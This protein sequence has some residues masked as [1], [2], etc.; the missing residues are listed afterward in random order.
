M[1]DILLECLKRIQ[2]EIRNLEQQLVAIEPKDYLKGN[3]LITAAKRVE[4]SDEFAKLVKFCA[5]VSGKSPSHLEGPLSLFLKQSGAYL[6]YNITDAS[7]VDILLENLH[8]LL[9]PTSDVSVTYLLSLPWVDASDVPVPVKFGNYWV[10]KLSEEDLENILNNQV[11]EVFFPYSSIDRETLFLL[12]QECWLEVN[13]FEPPPDIDSFTIDFSSLFGRITYTNLPSIVERALGCLILLDWHLHNDSYNDT[14]WTGLP[15]GTLIKISD[16]WFEPPVKPIINIMAY[17]FVEKDLPALLL[18]QYTCSDLTY[19]NE[20][21]N[22]LQ[23]LEGSE[24]TSFVVRHVLRYLLRAAIREVDGPGKAVQFIDHVLCLEALLG[25]DKPGMSGRLA[26]RIGTLI[27]RRKCKVVERYFKRIYKYRSKL[28]HG[29]E[30]DSIEP[31]LSWLARR[32][33]WKAIIRAVD[34]LYHYKVKGYNLSQE[35]FIHILDALKTE[36]EPVE[37]GNILQLWPDNDN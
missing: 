16:N 20:L 19:L 21:E 32:L 7:L 27:D 8:E 31:E 29:T 28:L 30:I 5:G 1:R 33:A 13:D 37:I 6:K 35:E 9:I 4:K 11:R 22:K 12:S 14:W 34:V 18:E 15:L 25:D 10:S 26:Q 23:E 2:T 3:L 17:D 24:K 36:R